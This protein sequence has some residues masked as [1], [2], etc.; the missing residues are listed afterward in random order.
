MNDPHNLPDE[1]VKNLFFNYLKYEKSTSFNTCLAYEN[2]LTQFFLFLK[3]ECIEW[4]S[5]DSKVVYAFLSKIQK[6]RDVVRST[7]ARKSASIKAFYRYAEKMGFI[8]KNPI[9]KMKAPKFRRPLPKPLRPIELEIM[10]EED[11]GQSE[12]IQLRDKA[13][14]EVMYSSGMRISEVLPLN[15]SNI[16]EFSGKIR[17]SIIITGKGG[18]QRVVFIGSLAKEAL[19]KYLTY[20]YRGVDMKPENQDMPLFVNHQRNRLTRQ[21]AVYVLKK[22]KFIMRGD[23]Q[24]SPHTMR[25][26]FATDLLNSGADIRIVQEMLGHTSISTTQN[27]TKVARE[28]LQNTFRNCHPHAK[29]EG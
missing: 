10:L 6:E 14:L 16:L 24:I 11:S 1:Q 28:K 7:Q 13:L 8:E 18:K 15:T 22:R 25:H 20:I 29:K 2:D 5:V 12:F 17:D 9:Q 19:G 3:I 4:Y 23:D 27:Y 21:G 26:S